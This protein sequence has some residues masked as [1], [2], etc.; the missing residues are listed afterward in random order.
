[1]VI[2]LFYMRKLCLSILC[3]IVGFTWQASAQFYMQG[4]MTINAIVNATHDSNSCMSIANENYMATIQNSFLNDS[5]LIIDQ[6]S[7][8]LMNAVVN[9][10]GQNPWYVPL[11]VNT[12]VPVITDDQLVG[13]MAYFFGIPLKIICS[14]DTLYNVVAN[15]ALN[16][17]N[18][19]GYAQV[20]G[21]VYIDNNNDCN[22]NT[23]DMPLQSIQLN[24]ACILNNSTG[25]YSGYGFTNIAGDYTATVQTSWLTQYTVSLPSIYQ[26]IFPSSNCNPTTYTFT[27]APQ[28]NVNFALQC[29]A[30]IDVSAGAMYPPNVR[31]NIP[32]SI[33]PFVNNIGCDSASGTITLVKDM[34]TV[35]NPTLSANPATYVNGDTL[36]WNYLNLT[37]LSNGAYWNSFFAGVHLTPTLAVNIG[38]TLHFAIMSTAPGNDI[39]LANNQMMFHLPVVNSYDPNM[40]EVMPKG[41]GPN[42]NIPANTN[43]L[44]YTVHFQNTGNAVAYNVSIID[45]LDAD[46][47]PSSLRIVGS[48]HTMYP[49]WLAPNVVKFNFYNIMLPDSNANEAKSHGAVTFNVSPKANLPIGTQIKNKAFIYFDF[50]TPI[51]TNTTLNTIAAPQSNTTISKIN[52]WNIYPN[53]ATNRLHI[54]GIE[55]GNEIQIFNPIGQSIGSFRAIEKQ[56]DID[57]SQWNEGLY[58]IRIG[59]ISQSFIKQ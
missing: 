41:D 42:G 3:L 49:E 11:N 39:N 20:N 18:P 50:N 40:K 6:N 16:V 21:K 22:F 54:D 55:P 56:M 15:Y 19:C 14:N 12:M 37:N 30:A 29:S 38:D 57:I 26:F 8:T 10:T 33:S 2:K 1:M 17:T 43:L 48:S 28:N 9:T 51:I 52:K 4:D 35:Y 53:P 23:G 24:A 32:F 44:T 59:H 36:R 27:T 34:H 13:N 7:G 25:M 31:P 45:T 5:I 47:N 46:V 58:F